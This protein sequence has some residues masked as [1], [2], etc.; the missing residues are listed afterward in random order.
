MTFSFDSRPLLIITQGIS[1]SGK[2]TFLK[3]AGLSDFALSTDKI[4]LLLGQPIYNLESGFSISPENDKKV[5]ELLHNVLKTRMR[6]KELVIVDAMHLKGRDFQSYRK[7]ASEFNYR[8]ICI[9][10]LST[11]TLEHALENNEKR[12]SPTYLSPQIIR[13]QMERSKH[14]VQ[15]NFKSWVE[16]YTP[17]EFL[18]FFFNQKPVDLSSYKEII[19]IGDLQGCYTV[20]EEFLKDG[21]KEDSFYIFLGDYTDR[22]IENGKV[23]N[24]ISSISELPNVILLEG[25]HEVHARIWAEGNIAR[26]K[27][28]EENTK[29]DLIENNVSKKSVLSL[30]KKLNT[31]FFYSFDNKE[32]LCTH[33][34]LHNIPKSLYLLRHGDF[35]RGIGSYSTNIDAMFHNNF[36][37][38]ATYQV[39]GH[40]NKMPLLNDAYPH[41][42]NLESEV[43]FGGDL[44]AAVLKEGQPF[45]IIRTKN[46]VFANPNESIQGFLSLLRD[47]N[48]IRER[49]QDSNASISSFNFKNTV[50]YDGTWSETNTKA[51]GL[52]INT[53]SKQIVARSYDKFFNLNEM[54]E[55]EIDTMKNTLSFPCHSFVKENG[56]LGIMGLDFLS[57]EILFASKSLIDGEFANYFKNIA[58]S[59]LSEAQL[60]TAKTMM[61]E[62]NISLV[63]EVIDPVNDPHIVEYTKPKIVLLDAIKRTPNFEKLSFEKLKFIASSL[64]VECKSPSSTFHTFEELNTWIDSIVENENIL[65]EGFVIEDAAGFMFKIKSYYYKLWKNRRKII[66]RINSEKNNS[67]QKFLIYPGDEEFANWFEEHKDSEEIKNTDGSIISIRKIYEK[68]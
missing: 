60:A 19:H 2:S 24:F 14:F 9:D 17:V 1:G 54:K 68:I 30:N 50:F 61:N 67:Y 6:R 48:S 33:T 43:E 41:S 58:L 13:D 20:L 66:N 62:K 27:E 56:F 29:P 40:R 22:G 5:F 44:S 47:D 26:S 18:D 3:E 32:V 31:Y 15:N 64:G 16:F 25:N 4:R 55:T 42:I 35:V 38:T 10:F 21:I 57:D 46:T 36:Q 51:R 8:V 49:V 63:F 53:V 45:K 52:F 39:H 12:V 37:N 34:G 65:H 28:F 59:S 23:L 11:T 7:L